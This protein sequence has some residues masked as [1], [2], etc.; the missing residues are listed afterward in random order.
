MLSNA[1]DWVNCLAFTLKFVCITG[2]VSVWATLLEKPSLEAADSLDLG[3][4]GSP[5]HTITLLVFMLTWFRTYTRASK[6]RGWLNYR[7]RRRLRGRRR[8]HLE[9]Y[10]R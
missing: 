6:P 9:A 10:E 3:L 4:A 1:D 7:A 8:M 5:C 2:V